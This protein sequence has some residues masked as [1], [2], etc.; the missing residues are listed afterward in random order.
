MILVVFGL[1]KVPQVGNS[2]LLLCETG[3]CVGTTCCGDI[4]GSQILTLVN[5]SHQDK[6]LAI[7]CFPVNH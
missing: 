5:L 4:Y 6:V 7:K 3:R 1:F 2:F